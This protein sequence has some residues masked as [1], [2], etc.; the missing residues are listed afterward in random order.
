MHR[1][2]G[3]YRKEAHPERLCGFP[4]CRTR[5]RPSRPW[6]KFCSPDCKKRNEGQT[7]RKGKAS[8]MTPEAA[9]R[10]DRAEA[11]LCQVEDWT[12][13]APSLRN[14]YGRFLEETKL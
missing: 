3:H 11:L 6:H 10:A 5:F 13:R 2:N 4:E 1:G 7:W 12:A 9:E 8:N 14:V